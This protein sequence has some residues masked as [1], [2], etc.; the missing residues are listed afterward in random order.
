M[1]CV[2][3]NI[4]THCQQYYLFQ[5]NTTSKRC[6]RFERQP[7]RYS[8]FHS[9][10]DM[11]SS[12]YSDT[13]LTT[14]FSF[15]CC[16]ALTPSLTRLDRMPYLLKRWQ[17]PISI[18][19]FITESEVRKLATRIA[20]FL[21][22]R[23]IVFSFYVQKTIT[24]DNIPYYREGKWSVRQYSK[25]MYPLNLLRDLSI[26]AITTTHYLLIDV[27]VFLSSSLYTHLRDYS[28]V[29]RNPNA[30]LF[31]PLFAYRDD[32]RLMKC[33]STNDCKQLYVWRA[34][35]TG[36]WN[37]IPTDKLQL[38]IG[39]NRGELGPF[40]KKYHVASNCWGHS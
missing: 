31:L 29:L 6:Q 21:S 18:A 5:L 36:S 26:E 30:V 2:D 13:T 14:Q 4:Y 9:F 25:G 16:V 40:G 19:I 38:R 20:P 28:N 15:V 7:C 39:V 33:Y 17:G 10:S 22:S 12:I 23:R 32:E 24:L 34:L 3:N 37:A 27:D 8:W 11:P 1:D 35:L